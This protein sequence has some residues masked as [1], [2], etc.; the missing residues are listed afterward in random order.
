MDAGHRRGRLARAHDRQDARQSAHGADRSVPGPGPHRERGPCRREEPVALRGQDRFRQLGRVLG[1][2]VV[3]ALEPFDP[4]RRTGDSRGRLGDFRAG[5]FGRRPVGLAAVHGHDK[6]RNPQRTPQIARALAPHRL[7]DGLVAI[8]REPGR[9]RSIG[10]NLE[11]GERTFEALLRPVGVI[12]PEVAFDRRQRHAHERRRRQ[13]IPADLPRRESVA[14][15]GQAA[16]HQD[17]AARQ[18]RMADGE[19]QDDV[20]AP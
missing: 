14:Q 12:G 13:P 7:Q 17:D 16:V 5:S 3:V 19:I 20:P 10:S 6:R 1:V 9:D 15:V 4:D 11:V 18:V 8:S 2:D